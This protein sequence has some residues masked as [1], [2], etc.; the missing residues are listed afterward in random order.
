[1]VGSMLKTFI[2][3][4]AASL[5]SFFYMGGA[6]A[7]QAEENAKTLQRVLKYAGLYQGSIDGIIGDNT[8]T[9][10]QLLFEIVK[11]TRKNDEIQLL[12]ALSD[13]ANSCMS[14]TVKLE[15]RIA[16]IGLCEAFARR[17]PKSS[18]ATIKSIV[19]TSQFSA[20][21]KSCIREDLHITNEFAVKV[22]IKALSVCR[23]IDYIEALP[24]ILPQWKDALRTEKFCDNVNFLIMLGSN[25]P[26]EAANLVGVSLGD[27]CNLQRALHGD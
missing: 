7:D 15:D 27:D 12:D 25:E 5:W 18:L 4:T 10:A 23:R 8:A 13:F 20:S 22:A 26:D 17:N 16:A 19:I 11:S 1:M 2:A 14:N 3:A 21:L 24:Q 6:L 9:A